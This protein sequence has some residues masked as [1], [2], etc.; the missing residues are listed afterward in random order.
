[1]TAQSGNIFDDSVTDARLGSNVSIAGATW[2]TYSGTDV[3]KTI[4]LGPN[5]RIHNG[6]INMPG[7]TLYIDCDYNNVVIGQITGTYT[8]IS[9]S[10]AGL[11]SSIYQSANLTVNWANSGN[12]VAH[13]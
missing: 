5:N 12:N 8:A 10:N 4:R 11:G 6:G 1:M 2:Y 13:P 7:K 3:S 9:V